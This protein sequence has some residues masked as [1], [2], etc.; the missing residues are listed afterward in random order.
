MS[1]VLHEKRGTIA[2]VTLNRPAQLNALTPS[3][4]D[5]LTE[6]V[7]DFEADPDLRVLILTGAGDRAFS[8]GA[9]LSR[10]HSDKQAAVL[11]VSEA[12]DLCGLG[13]C[14]KATITALNG[15]AVG[16]GFELSLCCDIR[17]AAD[18]VWFGLPET[19]RGFLAGVASVL[20]PRLMPLGIVMDMMLASRRLSAAEALMHG[21]VQDVVPRERLMEV[22]ME[23][24][25]RM[26]CA[27]QPALWGTKQAIRFWFE[28]LNGE[29]QRYYH[30]II[31]RVLMTGDIREGLQAFVEKRRPLF[32]T[33]EWPSP[34]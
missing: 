2:I 22:A 21:L 9:D 16:G 20:L 19:E 32:E 17:V 6:I 31:Q 28:A 18:H 14:R 5:E 3:I 29:H 7:A 30:M 1:D 4:F 15:L 34:L 8:S 25:E 24:A 23:K 10:M 13:R 12:P 26:A 27:S 11:P 33:N